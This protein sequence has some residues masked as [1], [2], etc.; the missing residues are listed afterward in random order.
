M[1]NLWVADVR[2]PTKARPLTRVTDR[3]LGPWIVWPHNNRYIVFFRE[4]G[5][6]ENWQAHRVDL[7]TG[8]ILA[9]TPGPGV[10]AFIQ[11]ISR[12]FPDELLIAHNRRDQRFSDIFRVNVVTGE[13][14]LVETNERFASIFTDPQFQIRYAIRQTDNGDTEYLQRG[15]GEEWE[16][17]TRIDMAD[18][19]STRAIEFSDDGT[20]LYWLT[21]AAATR[22]P[23]SRRTCERAR[24]GCSFTT[25][26]PMWSAFWPIRRACVPSPPR[27]SSRAR[28]GR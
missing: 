10:K 11:Q 22:P 19:I 18:A 26:G 28:A 25:R 27:R 17:F 15:A 9:L 12:H 16:L 5:G 4:Q 20:E 21:R 23:W 13:S 6:D 1:Q 3:D 24:S 14:T 8:D 7:S 2:D